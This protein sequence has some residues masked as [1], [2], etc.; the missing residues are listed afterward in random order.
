MASHSQGK[1]MREKEASQAPM[2]QSE[3]SRD[4]ELPTLQSEVESTRDNDDDNDIT[5]GPQIT[6]KA[7]LKK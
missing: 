7:T 1:G 2:Q 3:K 4:P 6:L 5:Q